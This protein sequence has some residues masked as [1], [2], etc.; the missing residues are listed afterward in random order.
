VNWITK[1]TFKPVLSNFLDLIRRI[2]ETEIQIN[3]SKDKGD[4][5]KWWDTD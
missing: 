1:G 3:T 4:K 5:K 2:L